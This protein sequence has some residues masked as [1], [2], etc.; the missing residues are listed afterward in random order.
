PYVVRLVPSIMQ[1]PGK[2]HLVLE[3][4]YLLPGQTITTRKGE[5]LTSNS[6]KIQFT[7]ISSTGRAVPAVTADLTAN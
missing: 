7:P 4:S 6:T 1:L 5:R 2:Q 3:Q